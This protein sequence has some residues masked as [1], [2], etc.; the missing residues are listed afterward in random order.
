MKKK[1][2]VSELWEQKNAASSTFSYGRIAS[3]SPVQVITVPTPLYG[4][5]LS[6]LRMGKARTRWEWG[7]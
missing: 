3:P 5:N 1:K 4:R 7:V 6:E 2:N